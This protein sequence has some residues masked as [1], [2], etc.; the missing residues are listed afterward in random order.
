MTNYPVHADFKKISFKLS[1]NPLFL[2]AS[3]P[4]TKLAYI[5]EK[6]DEDVV[7][8]RRKI[9]GFDGVTISVDL[10]SPKNNTEKL[11][12]LVFIHGG[13][14]VF[15]G[16]GYHKTIASM[17]AKQ[18]PCTVVSVNYR[19]APQYAYPTALE[20]CYEALLWVK[21]NAE[22]LN[23]DSSRIGVCGDSAGGNLAAALAQ[24]ARDRGNN[25]LFQLLVCPVLDA[26]MHTESMKQFPDT[27]VWNSV[28][29]KKMWKLYKGKTDMSKTPVYA[30]PAE[31]ENLKDLPPAFVEVNEFDCLRDEGIAYHER[32]LK[33]GVPSELNNTKGTIHG[34]ELN[35][36]SPVTQD[37]IAKRIAFAKKMFSLKKH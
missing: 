21:N 5:V 22:S 15:H 3:Q 19:L 23:I 8:E 20:D 1:L 24:A 33:A 14:F 11:P 29:N 13:G 16:I 18:I 36:K 10:L 37:M 6:I 30:S 17:F 25:L 12:C 9:P 4:V 27:P 34:V 28:L 7:W 2:L 35:F 26:R 32:L 31:T